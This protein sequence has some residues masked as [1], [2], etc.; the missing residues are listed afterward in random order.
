MAH[1]IN[2]NECIGCG[3]CAA[4]CPTDAIGLRDGVY[5]VNESMC[6]DCGACSANCPVDA[7]APAG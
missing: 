3:A 4:D 6:I 1:R 7:I 2:H 5:V